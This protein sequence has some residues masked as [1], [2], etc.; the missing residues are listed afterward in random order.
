MSDDYLKWV[1][2]RD[3]WSARVNDAHPARS[4]SHDEYGTAMQMI[5][6]R[7][8][9]QALVDLVNW[10]LVELKNAGAPVPVSATSPRT[11]SK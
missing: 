10:L 6:H 9:K 5:S 8:S 1:D 2:T 7:H 11:P 4:G 3:E